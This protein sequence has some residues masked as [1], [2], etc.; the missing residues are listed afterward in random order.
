MAYWSCPIEWPNA[1]AWIVCGGWSLRDVDLS[2]LETRKTIAIN[3]SIYRVPWADYLFFGDRRW[4]AEHRKTIPKM[5]GR[6]VTNSPSVREESVLSMHKVKPPP[7]ISDDRTVLPMSWTSLGPSINLAVHLGAKRIILVGADL[8]AAPD[9]TT[10][11]HK[12]HPWPL[13]SRWQSMQLEALGHC[14]TPLRKRGIEV[15][16]SNPSSALSYWPKR[17]LVDCLKEFT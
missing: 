12:P 1:T 6:I 13:N 11:H 5:R 10:H 15:I 17:N 14:V 16:N 2:P 3:S 7:G 9:G 4:Y 8:N